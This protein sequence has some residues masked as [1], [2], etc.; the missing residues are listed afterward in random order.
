VYKDEDMLT[1]E[2]K[3]INTLIYKLGLFIDVRY[4]KLKQYGADEV[5]NVMSLDIENKSC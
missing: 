4:E 2:N 3:F 1:Y 5:S